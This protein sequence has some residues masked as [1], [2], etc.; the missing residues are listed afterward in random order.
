MPSSLSGAAG[1]G[2]G[3]SLGKWA[4]VGDGKTSFR[5]LFACALLKLEVF[6]GKAEV[7][8]RE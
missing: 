5:R 6:Q 4:D 8:G 3:F 1:E 2:K 7:P